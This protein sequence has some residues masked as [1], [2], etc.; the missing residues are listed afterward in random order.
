MRLTLAIATAALSLAGCSSFSIDA[1]RPGPPTV[2][3]RLDSTPPGAD[4]LT[5]AGPGCKTP[6]AV[7]VAVPEGGFSVT[8]TMNG[9]RTVTLPVQLV[10]GDLTTP[11]NVNPNPVVAEL[12]AAAPPPKATRKRPAKPRR[13]PRAAP[14]PASGSPFPDQQQPP[15]TAAPQPPTP[16]PPPGR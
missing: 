11:A 5:S 14:A 15:A 12:E 13:P 2:Q 3:V 4:A 8:F 10:Q 7:E 16:P 1:F 9:Y 6:C